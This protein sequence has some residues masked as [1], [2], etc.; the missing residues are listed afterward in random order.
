MG[1]CWAERL[2][3][4]SEPQ[5]RRLDA[6]LQPVLFRKP[7]AEGTTRREV[8]RKPRTLAS[9]SGSEIVC[10]INNRFVILLRTVNRASAGVAVRW[11]VSISFRIR[12]LPGD[13]ILGGR[14]FFFT[15]FCIEISRCYSCGGSSFHRPF[16]PLKFV[17]FLC[18]LLWSGTLSPLFFFRRPDGGSVA[19]WIDFVVF[20]CTFQVAISENFR[21]LK[22]PRSSRSSRGVRVLLKR[23]ETRAC[24]LKPGSRGGFE[25]NH[26][27]LHP[28]TVSFPFRD[29]D[30]MRLK[31]EA[32]KAKSASWDKTRDNSLPSP[33][34]NNVKTLNQTEAGSS[35]PYIFCLYTL[36]SCKLHCLSV[37]SDS[38]K[39][40]SF[41]HMR[42]CPSLLA[43]PNDL[44][45][46][47][48]MNWRAKFEIYLS[49]P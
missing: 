15:S 39:K 22:L 12:N 35:S 45:E 8:G 9:E 14:Q 36:F 20:S 43:R 18:F 40:N 29:A 46:L 11:L 37:P 47:K 17:V 31:Q 19:E 33:G 6:A 32:A 44:V 23:M 13:F 48:K 10:I 42:S 24:L 49:T 7:F 25:G 2:W 16:F 27:S 21:V 34:T 41:S 5:W 30:Q 28:E 3:S 38:I 4:G 1:P 26:W